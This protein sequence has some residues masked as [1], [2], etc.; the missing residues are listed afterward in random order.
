M[1]HPQDVFSYITSKP[2]GYRLAAG[3]RAVHCDDGD[4]ARGRP[5]RNW[6][7][8]RY[9]VRP[10]EPNRLDFAPRR[11]PQDAEFIRARIEEAEARTFEQREKQK[12]EDRQRKELAAKE[13]QEYLQH[14]RKIL[15][16]IR[17]RRIEQYKEDRRRLAL[18]YIRDTEYLQYDKRQVKLARQFY[19]LS[20]KNL[21]RE[22]YDI[23]EWLKGEIR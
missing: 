1:E 8:I 14:Q 17:Q 9:T 22:Y 21:E 16:E 23:R 10:L 12:L 3:F 20:L 2:N 15:E 19:L 18:R 7:Q 6:R 5:P 4:T 13:R 11:A